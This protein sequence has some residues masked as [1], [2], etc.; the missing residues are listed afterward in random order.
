MRSLTSAHT[1]LIAGAWFF[2]YLSI[3]SP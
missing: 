1:V 2:P 3:L